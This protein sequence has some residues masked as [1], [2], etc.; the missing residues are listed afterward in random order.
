[1]SLF[2][3]RVSPARKVKDGGGY[4]PGKGWLGLESI[5]AEASSHRDEDKVVSVD[6]RWREEEEGSSGNEDCAAPRAGWTADRG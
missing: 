5:Y 6:S 1:L 2:E 4:A 3:S